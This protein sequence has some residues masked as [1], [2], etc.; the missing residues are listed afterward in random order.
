MK[1]LLEHIAIRILPHAEDVE[2]IEEAKEDGSIRLILITNEEDTGLAIGKGGKTA[3][4][5][6]ELLKIK[7]IQENTKIYLDIKS[8]TEEDEATEESP[9]ALKTNVEST[10]NTQDDS[11]ENEEETTE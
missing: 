1:E 3:H 9:E 8:N 5:L 7:A 6:R 10:P 2:V 11:A 4:A